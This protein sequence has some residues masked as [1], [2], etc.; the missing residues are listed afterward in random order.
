MTHSF[1]HTSGR[2]MKHWDKV[3]Y[4]TKLNELHKDG[5]TTKNMPNA[6]TRQPT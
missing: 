5:I 2:T 1:V 6:T 4:I 3:D